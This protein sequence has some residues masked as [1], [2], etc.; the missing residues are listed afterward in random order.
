MAD[1]VCGPRMR[2]GNFVMDAR[3]W[4]HVLI[5]QFTHLPWRHHVAPAVRR[6]PRHGQG[7]R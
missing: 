5:K 4:S 1:H 2:S 7:T 3:S 6:R